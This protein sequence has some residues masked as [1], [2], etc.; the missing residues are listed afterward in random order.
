MWNFCLCT[1]KLH[2]L[3]YELLPSF[4]EKVLL[5]ICLLIYSLP[6]CHVPAYPLWYRNHP[7]SPWTTPVWQ[8]RVSL[9]PGQQLPTWQSFS[10]SVLVSFY[11]PQLSSALLHT[12]VEPPAAA[13][14]IPTGLTH[15]SFALLLEKSSLSTF[16]PM[17]RRYQGI[18]PLDLP[19]GL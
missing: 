11:S 13:F 3:L 17:S 2:T 14:P 8:N 10:Y 6:V 15:T 12:M 18:L 4:R 16:W 19:Q 5:F 1:K 9:S 7:L